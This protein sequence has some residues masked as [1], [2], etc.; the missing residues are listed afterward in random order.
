MN[1]FFEIRFFILF[2]FICFYLLV[3]VLILIII[4]N[5]S[6]IN[7]VTSL[8]TKKKLI[9]VIIKVLHFSLWL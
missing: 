4:H 6:M 2:F 3:F 7:F 8:S 1:A 5:A 9:N